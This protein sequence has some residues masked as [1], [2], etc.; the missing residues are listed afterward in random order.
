MKSLT[1]ILLGICA[2]IPFTILFFIYFIATCGNL[3]ESGK[4]KQK[5]ALALA[6]IQSQTSSQIKMLSYEEFKAQ[7]YLE[8]FQGKHTGIY[9]VDG[10]TP[11]NSEARLI[12]Y[13]SE[14]LLAYK[15]LF[16]STEIFNA[17]KSIVY[18]TNGTD[19]IWTSTQKLQLTYCISNLFGSRKAAVIQAMADASFAWESVTLVDFTYVPSEDA[20]CSASNG[21]VMFD[22]ETTSGQSYV[23]RSFFPNF[24]RSDRNILIDDVA[25]SYPSPLSVTG[26]L[27]H[28]LG[29]VLGLRHEHTRPEAGVCFEDNQWRAL[30]AYDSNSVMQYPQCHGTGDY[31]F[32]L[33]NLDKQGIV[34]I[35][36]AR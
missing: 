30:T 35:Y 27:R 8:I 3:S 36:G 13:Y 12:K 24:P 21:N 25:F 17:D 34:S 26:F 9:I 32:S 19:I 5:E 16:P 10:H 23:A 4:R 6:Y 15:Q 14:Y 2:L 18:N 11:A 33:T 7:A 20:N 28:E 31:S 1:K 22:V 29:H